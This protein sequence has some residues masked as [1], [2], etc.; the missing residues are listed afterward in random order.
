MNQTKSTQP[1]KKSK[2]QTCFMCNGLAFDSV[3]YSVIATMD[4]LAAL[5][6][7]RDSCRRRVL[8]ETRPA[9]Q[10]TPSQPAAARRSPRRS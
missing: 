8:R 7:K 2:P 10:H 9:T 3:G 4:A 5:M 6:Q 1:A